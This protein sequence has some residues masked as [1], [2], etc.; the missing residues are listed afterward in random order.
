VICDLKRHIDEIELD[1]LNLNEEVN[2]LQ[3]KLRNSQSTTQVGIE[4][5]KYEIKNR[6]ETIKKLR[7]DI[8]SIQDKREIAL[9][10]VTKHFFFLTRLKTNLSR[11]NVTIQNFNLKYFVPMAGR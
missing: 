4:S 6:D 7:D 1:K 10:D 5:L 8:L 2:Q 11:A 9:N 3:M